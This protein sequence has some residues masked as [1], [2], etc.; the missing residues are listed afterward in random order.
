LAGSAH[1]C[2][3]FYGFTQISF[4]EQGRPCAM[5]DSPSTESVFALIFDYASEGTLQDYLSKHLKTGE[6]LANWRVIISALGEVADGLKSLHS[7]NVVH[8]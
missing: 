1:S 8:R 5:G 6:P 7:R 2:I 4:D 3:D